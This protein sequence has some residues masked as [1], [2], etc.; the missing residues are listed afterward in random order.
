[1]IRIPAPNGSAHL[2][3]TY[4]PPANLSEKAAEMLAALFSFSR[5]RPTTLLVKQSAL[6]NLAHG[7]A[8]PVL[9]PQILSQLEQQER[10]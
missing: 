6:L 3:E 7:F 10:G 2:K 4:F 8:T 9:V 1:M 5:Y